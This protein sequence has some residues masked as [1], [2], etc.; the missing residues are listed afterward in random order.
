MFYLYMRF[1]M[2][3]LML[4]YVV[5]NLDFELI[6]LKYLFFDIWKVVVKFRIF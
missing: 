6:E 2:I 3:F 5:I 4:K 1:Y